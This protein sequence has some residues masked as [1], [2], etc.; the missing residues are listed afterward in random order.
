MKKNMDATCRI[1]AVNH[2]VDGFNQDT[3][4][5]LV[6]WHHNHSL[7]SRPIIEDPFDPLFPPQ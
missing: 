3:W 1:V 2:G 7:R 5:L 4:V 6:Y